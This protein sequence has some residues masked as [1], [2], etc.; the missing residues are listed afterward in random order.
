MPPKRYITPGDARKLRGLLKASHE[1]VG[2]VDVRADGRMVFDH[3][4]KRSP[5]AGL[6]F[7]THNRSACSGGFDPPSRQDL[8]HLCKWSRTGH[9]VVSHNGMYYIRITC[10][11]PR[12]RVEAVCK[13]ITQ[14][15]KRLGPGAAYNAAWMRAA[16][17]LDASCLRVKFISW[18]RLLGA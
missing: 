17:S 18:K 4:R 13:N 14:L 2:R 10:R 15:Q 7:H 8:R 9:Y 6:T 1:Y 12:P 5:G 16:N 11:V 3:T